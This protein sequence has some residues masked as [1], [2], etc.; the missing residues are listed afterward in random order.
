MR[1]F[2]SQKSI[3]AFVIVILIV[4]GMGFGL[5]VYLSQNQSNV[6][7]VSAPHYQGSTNQKMISFTFN[8]DWG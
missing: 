5:M 3:K 7:R 8:V 1:I 2:I 4:V 6:S